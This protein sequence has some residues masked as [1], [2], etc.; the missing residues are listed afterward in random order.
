[1][2]KNIISTVL[3]LVFIF[4][5]L[6]AQNV[7]PEILGTWEITSAQVN[8]VPQN[9]KDIIKLKI[10]STTYFTWFSCSKDNRITRNSVGGTCSFDGK[11]YIEYIEFVGV[12]STNM[13]H[14]KHIFNVVIKGNIM[15][16]T[17]TLTDNTIIEEYWKRVDGNKKLQF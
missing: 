3:F 5:R 10:I 6:N 11:K 1:M 2:K 13:L 17:G 9:I 16:L 8:S 4:I 15:H 7:K 14:K 12:G